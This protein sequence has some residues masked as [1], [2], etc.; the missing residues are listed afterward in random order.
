MTGL[1]DRVASSGRSLVVQ[2][3]AAFA[4]VF[5]A[6]QL[7]GSAPDP[8]LFAALAVVTMCLVS[9][10]GADT[11][12]PAG[13]WAAEDLSRVGERWGSDHET[14]ALARDLALLREN[15]TATAELAVRVHRRIGAILEARV[16]H[17]NSVDL[18]PNPQWARQLL[19]EDLAEVYLSPPDAGLLRPERLAQLV[20]RMEAW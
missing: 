3:V 11:G 8:L 6:L 7:L 18:R 16:W 14:T 17:T 4:V 13:P 2:L 10:A 1:A 5:V 15:P 20:A 19:P 12:P 9:A